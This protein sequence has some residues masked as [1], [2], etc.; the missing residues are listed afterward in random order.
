MKKRLLA[1][2]L[3][4][5]MMVSVCACGDANADKNSQNSADKGSSNAQEV[6]QPSIDTLADYSD[7][8][9][10]L[11]GDYEITEDVLNVYF[12]E[13]LYSAGLGIIKVTDRD[14]VQAGDIV[15]ADYTGFVNDQKFQGGA[16]TQ[17]WLDVSNNCGI[18][19][20]TGASSGGFIE[21]FTD[22]LIGAKIDEATDSP[23]V[24]PASYD[25]DTTLEDGSTVNLA[26]QPAVFQFVV[27]EIYEEVTPENITDDFVAENLSSVYDVNTVEEFMAFLK[28]DL[29]YTFTI[30]YVIQNSTF[31]IPESYLY[32]RLEDYQ[33]YFE[34][35]YCQ[36]VGL[37]TYLSYYGT[38]LDQMQVQW[39]SQI[40]SQ[41]KAELVFA[42]IVEKSNLTLD[43]EG[44]IA[45]VQSIMD[46]NGDY[47]KD[48]ESV[49]KYA[50]SGNAEAG[51]AYMKNQTAV[52]NNFVA[53]YDK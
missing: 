20:T 38:T 44:H 47:F 31:T 7:M 4:A 14:T 16:A 28:N 19:I 46:A 1:M 2:L 32:A 51:E 12:S 42:A 37:E 13:V 52:R 50:G 53:N 6:K 34:E 35:I 48:A 8:S 3:C 33:A 24:F 17:Q 29:T 49:H 45:Y 5:A 26:N 30:N 39:L 23:I 15:K 27:H 36:G 22:G 41:I 18:D 11:S 21:G 10:V 25:S 40:N 9:V 43:E